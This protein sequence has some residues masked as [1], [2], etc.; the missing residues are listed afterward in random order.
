MKLIFFGTPACAALVLEKILQAPHQV[1]AVITQPDKPSGRGL[2]KNPSPVKE[3]ALKNNLPC[4]EPEKLKD[5]VFYSLIKSLNPDLMVVVA[6]GRILPKELLEIPKYGAINLHT[7]LLPKYRGAAPIEWAIFHGEKKLGATIMKIA[8]TLDTGDILLQ[9][10]IKLGEED[11]V[12]EASDKLFGLGA[13]LMLKALDEIEKGRAVF[14]PQDE[15]KA[16]YAPLIRKEMGI[17]DWKKSALE[18]KN[19]IR[20]FSRWPGSFT[21]HNQKVLKVLKVKLLPDKGA[22]A[23]QVLEVKKGEGFLVACGQGSLM[24]EEVQPENRKKMRAADF[25]LGYNIQPGTIFP[26]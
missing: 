25:I 15:K 11:L 19:Q 3:S 18:I 6:Y 5:P 13:K 12:E 2:K 26:N 23:G 17:I 9:D 20:A 8:E 14:T 1:L 16:T 4:F 7:S 22:I 24:V 10:A 21:Y